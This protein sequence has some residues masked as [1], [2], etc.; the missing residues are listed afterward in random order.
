MLERRNQARV[1]NL[2]I[3]AILQFKENQYQDIKYRFSPAIKEVEESNKRLFE[4]AA[5]PKLTR[6]IQELEAEV[7][8]KDEAYAKLGAELEA[9][10]ATHLKDAA[11]LEETQKEKEERVSRC[12]HFEETCSQLRLEV[13]QQKEKHEAELEGFRA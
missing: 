1:E 2:H 9:V 4:A 12:S 10:H 11:L 5:P 8:A 6:R 3:Q 13:S 7:S